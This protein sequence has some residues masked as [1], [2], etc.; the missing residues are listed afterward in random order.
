MQCRYTFQGAWT[1]SRRSAG[2]RRTARDTPCRSVTHDRYIQACN[3]I[4]G[5]YLVARG[6]GKH[7]SYG[8]FSKISERR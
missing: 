8:I 4:E 5:Y 6:R 3:C 2:G 1:A 7:H